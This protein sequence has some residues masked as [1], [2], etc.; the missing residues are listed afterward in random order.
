MLCWPFPMESVWQ[1]STSVLSSERKHSLPGM[2]TITLLTWLGKNFTIC[3][4]SAN[5][6]FPDELIESMGFLMLCVNYT[7]QMA[8]CWMLLWMVCDNRNRSTATGT[9]GVLRSRSP[10]PAYLTRCAAESLFLLISAVFIGHRKTASFSFPEVHP[11][12][13]SL[14]PL[15]SKWKEAKRSKVFQC[16]LFWSVF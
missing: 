8:A 4:M 9:Y 7:F 2:T 6:C 15:I 1:V 16:L 13:Y 12:Q 5:I 14:M 3:S 10:T 11:L